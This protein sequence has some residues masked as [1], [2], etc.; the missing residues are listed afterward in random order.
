MDNAQTSSIY[1]GKKC[2]RLVTP[3]RRP[4]HAGAQGALGTSRFRSTSNL[5]ASAP[6]RAPKAP[7]AAGQCLG[8]SCFWLNSSLHQT[9]LG[10][11]AY[12]IGP[13]AAAARIDTT[14]RLECKP[15]PSNAHI[16]NRYL[17]H[18]LH[19]RQWTVD[20]EAVSL[21][22][23]ILFLR[24]RSSPHR[25]RLVKLIVPRSPPRRFSSA[26]QLSRRRIYS[27]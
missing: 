25:F 3:D 13:P 18:V 17:L 11:W 14:V 20:E 12:A 19:L 2:S 1:Y 16:S 15:I 7:S 8:S 10:I 24:A 6:R 21:L 5:M 26:W 4:R 22:T 9:C 27:I 23:V